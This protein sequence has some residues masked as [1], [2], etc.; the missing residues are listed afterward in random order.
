M[1]LYLVRDGEAERIGSVPATA[2]GIAGSDWI[3]VEAPDEEEALWT[4]TYYDEAC[5]K[6]RKRWSP[7]DGPI[8]VDNYD[9]GVGS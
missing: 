1:A 3:A 8:T 7:E 4:A 5:A 2:S 6:G 9:A